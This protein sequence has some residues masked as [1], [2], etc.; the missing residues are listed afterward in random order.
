MRYRRM[1]IEAESPEELGYDTIKCNLAESSV[2]DRNWKELGIIPSDLKLAYT[3][4][5]GYLP[6]RELIAEDYGISPND[7]LLTPGAAGALFIVATSLLN[8]NNAVL[9]EHPNYATNLETPYAI[10]CERLLLP[11]NFEQQWKPDRKKIEKMLNASVQLLSFTQPHNPTGRML[12]EVELELLSDMAFDNKSYLLLDETYRELSAHPTPVGTSF[13]EHVISVSSLSKAF[14]VPGIRMGWIACRNKELMEL[15]LAAKEQI[16]ICNSILDEYVA[17]N[18]YVN[19]AETLRAIQQRNNNNFG[20]LK[21]FVESNQ[22]LEWVE[23][24]GGVVCFPRM[25]DSIDTDKFY[26]LLQS[27]YKTMVGPGH[28]F[29]MPD[30]YMR[31]GF[32]WPDEKEFKHGLDNLLACYQ[33]IKQK[34]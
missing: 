12:S 26:S 27:Q 32:G 30:S 19:K 28:W 11:L 25:I 20:V 15:F 14:G 6:L 4:H 2:S 13:G 34:D 23:P 24:K 18:C 22:M 9:V 10:G 7:V 16:L 17:W 31:I 1:P 21:S 33:Q 29:E 8:K 3:D 5:R